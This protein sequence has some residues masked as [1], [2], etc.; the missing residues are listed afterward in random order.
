MKSFFR[1]ANRRAS[2]THAPDATSFAGSRFNANILL[3]ELMQSQ[4][5]KLARK[6]DL[7]QDLRP[8][9]HPSVAFLQGM[10]LND[11]ALQRGFGL[12]R[13]VSQQMQPGFLQFDRDEAM[14]YFA[15][16][17]A[18]MIC[19]GSWDY[20]SIK[21]QS[22]FEIGLFRV[23]LPSPS[24]PE[25][26][27]QVLGPRAELGSGIGAYF[28]VSQKSEHP[29]EAI[30]F[31]RFITSRRGNQAFVKISR[32]VPVVRGARPVPE[33]EPFL[34]ST[35]GVPPGLQ[36]APLMWGSGELYRVQSNQMHRLMSRDGGVEPFVD[37]L[38]AEVSAAA[39]RDA[40]KTAQGQIDSV[41]R[42][43]ALLLS[44]LLRGGRRTD[45]YSGLMETQASREANYYWIESLR[46]NARQKP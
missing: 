6:L 44:T 41:R 28:F 32:G 8:P 13:E 45:A 11:V 46:Q 27:P 34:P 17:R 18:L 10:T 16:Q 37:A 19:S 20:Y 25:Y 9:M 7:L 43:D 22:P 3:G 42:M 1:S 36:I 30:D 14:F 40:M 39:D 15:Q 12:M 38:Q 35:D 33:V 2:S 24:H 31:L 29:E 4:T 23:P 26:G 21:H 5:Q